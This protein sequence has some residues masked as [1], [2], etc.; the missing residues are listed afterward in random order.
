[1]V[2]SPGP[3]EPRS[4]DFRWP[5][6]VHGAW[7]PRMI[8]PAAVPAALVSQTGTRATWPRV[9]VTVKFG[10]PGEKRVP[11]AG[12]SVMMVSAVSAPREALGAGRQRPL[13]VCGNATCPQSVW[14]R[15]EL[16]T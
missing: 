16:F 4:A 6:A 8:S 14:D 13:A 5:A 12:P 15:G 2:R 7:T 11:V 1:M 3:I 10:Y 9:A